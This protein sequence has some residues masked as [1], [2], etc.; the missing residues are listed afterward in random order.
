MGY[1]IDYYGKKNNCIPPQRR[2]GLAWLFFGIFL[3]LVCAFW[4][5]GRE[6][7][8]RCLWPGD[9]EDF[10]RAA[11]LFLDSVECGLSFE[12]SAAI[13]CREV[14]SGAQLVK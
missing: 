2:K 13:F 4:T 12:D 10:R 5:E 1:R 11:G 7:L 14:L 6:V 8:I 9:V 3:L